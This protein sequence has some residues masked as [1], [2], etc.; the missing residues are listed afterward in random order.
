MRPPT[1]SG[2]WCA[3]IRL[4]RPACAWATD[5]DIW[6]RRSHPL[7]S[8]KADTDLDLLTN[9]IEV[10]QEDPEFFIRKAIGWALRLRARTATGCAPSS[11]RIRGCPHSAD[12]RPSSAA[13]SGAA[14]FDRTCGGPRSYWHS[15]P[16]EHVRARCLSRTPSVSIGTV[17]LTH[18]VHVVKEVLTQ[19]LGVMTHASGPSKQNRHGMRSMNSGPETGHPPSPGGSPSA[20]VVVARNVHSCIAQ[21]SSHPDS[22]C[23]RLEPIETLHAASAMP[24]PCRSRSRQHTPQRAHRPLDPRKPGEANLSAV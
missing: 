16:S 22:G 20:S 15:S 5:P 11:R 12:A 24:Q 7:P 13:E 6:V 2:W 9:V 10:N 14:A 3:S 1:P 8:H 19:A 18:E 17:P 23:D 21:R 4:R